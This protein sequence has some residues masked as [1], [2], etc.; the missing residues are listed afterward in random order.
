[1]LLLVD[2]GNAN[3]N[4]P[5]NFNKTVFYHF[6]EI[7]TNLFISNFEIKA[8]DALQRFDHAACRSFQV[9]C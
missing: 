8:R 5:I 6:Y 3:A 7:A 9:T 1:M 4:K 2:N